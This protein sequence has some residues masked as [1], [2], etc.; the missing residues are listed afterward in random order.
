MIGGKDNRGGVVNSAERY[1]LVSNNWTV[2]KPSI[3]KRYAGCAIS[4]ANHRK[5]ITFGG[6]TSH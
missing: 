3:H 5:I 1:S 4:I 2:L 6:R